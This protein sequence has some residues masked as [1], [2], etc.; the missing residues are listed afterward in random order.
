LMSVQKMTFQEIGYKVIGALFSQHFLIRK[1]RNLVDHT[2]V[3]DAPLVE[4]EQDVYSLELFHGPTLAFKGLWRSFL[5]QVDELCSLPN[6]TKRFVCW[7]QL[8]ETQEVR[9]ANGFLGVDGVEVIILFPKGKSVNFRKSS[10][11]LWDKILLHWK[12]MVF[13][14]IVRSWLKEAFLDAEPE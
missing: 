1:S 14:M 8:L 10:L 11:Q 3:F 5:F 9:V 12:W 6:Q 13:L 7:W 2:L 4:V